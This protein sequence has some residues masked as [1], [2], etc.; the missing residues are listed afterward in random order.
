MSVNEHEEE[1][2]R[3]VALQNAQSILLAHRRAEE[4]LHRQSEW[5]RITLSSIG[6]AVITTDAGGRITFMNVVAE[7]LTG[8]SHGGALGRL[9]PEVFR[10]INERTR[11][12]ADN[13]ALSALREGRIVGL[14]NHTV[15]I[16]RDGRECPIDDSAAPMLG[17]SGTPIGT[18]LV[19]RD[20]T[21]RKRAD[22]VRARLAAIVESSDDAIVSKSLEGIIQSW[23]RG[24][25]RV[26]GYTA[27]E[28]VG[29]PITLIIPPELHDEER[30]ILARLRRGERIDHYETVR[31]GKDG[32]QVEVSLT[33]SPVRDSTGVIVGA[34]KIGRDISERRRSEALL[35]ESEERAV[36]SPTICPRA[37]STRSSIGPMIRGS[38][39]TLSAGVEALCGV[40]A[41]E[42]MQDP[43]RLYGLIAEEDQAR[44]RAAE[45][46]AM[47]DFG[48]FD[49]EFRVH[50]RG[51]RLR[52][53]HCRSA[54]RRQ[55]DSEGAIW[56]GIAIDVTDRRRAEQ[57]L[58]ASRDQLRIILRGVADGITVQ[59]LDGRLLFANEGAAKLTGCASPEELLATPS[60]ELMSRFELFDEDGRPFSSRDLPGRRALAGEAT[61]E[62]VIKFRVVKTG[63][64]RWSLVRANAVRDSRGEIQFSI[65]IFHEITDRKRAEQNQQFLADVGAVLAGS[66]DFQTTL[67]SVARLC[68]PRLADWCAVDVLEPNG[69]P[70]RLAVAHVDPEK[71]RWAVDI[72]GRYPPESNSPRGVHQ[73]IRT[74][75]PELYPEIPDQR[76]VEAVATPSISTFFANWE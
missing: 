68:V 51:G 28:A 65:S 41:L 42:V 25:E 61:P 63:E 15:L 69:N 57:E 43:R 44:V 8:W 59:D 21:E 50:G 35:R 60:P 73:V 45:D 54:P 49:C 29:Q 14:A 46:A 37:S 33:I 52:W 24:A 2:L 75:E 30:D 18:V 56:D 71:V 9:L 36:N 62:A 10:I 19:F 34:S 38:S 55:P 3:T 23:N 7:R 74:G 6:D 4:E 1:R 48:T 5:L 31:V 66:L 64:E 40:T 72:Q 32:R 27:A 13:P 67:T 53:L 70:R 16:S 22:E 47:R 17:E 39:R 76:L 12:P 58:A 20:V 11:Q 26:F